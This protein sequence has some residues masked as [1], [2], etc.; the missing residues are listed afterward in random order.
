VITASI[1]NVTGQGRPI[2]CRLGELSV[3]RGHITTEHPRDLACQAWPR[4]NRYF[5]AGRAQVGI[6]ESPKGSN[7][8]KYGAAYGFNGVT[9]CAIC[10]WWI[11]S[12]V[13]V[14]LPVKAASVYTLRDAF[15]HIGR[16]Y[17]SPVPGD[18]VFINY[19]SGHTGIVES[20]QPT[21]TT[22]TTIEGNTSHPFACRRPVASRHRVLLE[23]AA[24]LLV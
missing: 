2:D 17:G 22:I 13:G 24:A 20:V 15:K 16:Y 5:D 6:K 21:T 4:L 9:W 7:K 3:S 19:G 18:I 12:Q 14:G 8:R 10:V 1:A 11:T 23:I